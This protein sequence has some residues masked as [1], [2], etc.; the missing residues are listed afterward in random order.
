[1]KVI[2]L[3]SILG[4]LRALEACLAQAATEG[5]DLIVHTG[6]VVGY[7]PF[8]DACMRL[9]HERNIPGVR[10]RWED[11]LDPADPTDVA[12][13]L[14][15][16]PRE[17]ALARR[18]L[19]WNLRHMQASTRMLADG[20]PF[21]LQRSVGGRT[22]AVYHAGPVSLMDQIIPGLPQE[23]FTSMLDAAGAG[24]VGLGKGPEPFHK[25]VAGRHVVNAPR[26]GLAGATHT[27]YAV[28]TSEARVEVAFR[29]IPYDAASLADDAARQGLPPELAEMFSVR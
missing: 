8:P 27:G 23:A 20:L 5:C 19:E 6:D 17:R 28:I 16:S 11:A 25:E 3:G 18:A 29:R 26:L 15:D 24:I 4:N 14:A 21:E 2:L 7:G 9:L 1:M 22:L 10:G 12:D 13:M